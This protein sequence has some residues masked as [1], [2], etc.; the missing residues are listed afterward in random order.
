MKILLVNNLYSPYKIGGAELSVKIM[1]EYLA[2]KNLQVGV[3]T[4]GEE[5]EENLINN[6]KLYRLKLE[7]YYWPFGVSG[8]SKFDKFKWHLKDIFNDKYLF[9]VN[10]IINKFKPDIIHTNNLMGFSVVIW[11]IARKKKIKIVHTL[12]DYYLECP[13][14]NKFKKNENCQ[15]HC[16]ECKV[17]SFKKRIISQKVDQ[18]VGIS[19]SILE[20]HITS[21]YF[22]KSQKH[23]IYNG[24]EINS[25]KAV[26]T[27]KTFEKED[28]LNFGFIGQ[29]I[30]AKG[31]SFLVKNLKK[32][33]HYDNWKLF[34]AGRITEDY[35]IFLESLLPNDKIEFMGYVNQDF[36]FKKIDVLIVPSI[37][38]EPF[39]RVA[40]EGLI[41]NTV[42]IGSSRGG[43][44]EILYNNQQ[45]LFKPLNTE[46]LELLE[47][48][49]LDPRLL[50]KFDFDKDWINRFSIQNTIRKYIDIYAKII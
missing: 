14:T 3:L 12:R 23:V 19:N 38:E 4:L 11:E 25:A 6:V 9:T 5:Q 7:N 27:N 2:K 43:L 30:E 45:F 32:F 48:I 39:G 28:F 24:F 29:V 15:D 44:K 8:K 33:V 22:K 17:F 47:R 36:F 10:D 13:K 1:A 46:F 34:I 16:F 50:N 18:V 40:L 21:G 49:I 37:W 31:V 20:S 26:I 35:K 41:N 42:V